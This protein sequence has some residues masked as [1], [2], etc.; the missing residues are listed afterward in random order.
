MAGSSNFTLNIKA[1]FDASSVKAGVNEIQ[2][3]L[4]SLKLPDKL[5]TDLNSSFANVNKA[6]DDFTSKVEKGVKN[7]GDANG[8]TKSF[9]N[10]TKELT[11][12]DNLM[13]K[14]KSQL[15]EGVDLT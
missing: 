6:L 15:G 12:L 10:V 1:L 11:K 14:V 7:K 2:N 4:K 13:I 5:A 9:E 3:S 8:I